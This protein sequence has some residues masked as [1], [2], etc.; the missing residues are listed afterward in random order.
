[1][2]RALLEALLLG[3]V[4][5]VC[6]VHVVLRRLAFLT[7]ALQHTVFPGVAIA[8]LAGQSLLL[9]AAA[10]AVLSVVLLGLTTRRPE[11]DHDGALALLTVGFFSIGVITVS[12]STSFQ[13][14]L[15]ALL[16]GRLLAVDNRQL[17]ETAALAALGIVVLVAV[18]KELLLRA[19]DPGGAAALG[20]RLPVLDLVLDLVVA[21]VVV[22]GARAAGTML[23]VGFVVTPAAA[24][25]LVC[26]RVPTMMVVAA[27]LAATCAWVGLGISFE[28]S[29]GH[30][31]RVAPGAAVV[32]AFTLV[33][34]VMAAT[35]AVVARTPRRVSNMGQP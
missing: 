1:M 29:V 25:R 35:R 6:G 23:V 2:A 26:R 3:T 20:Y 34:A 5:A 16:F 17:V 19:F 11:V 24:A 12:R 7:D 13:G 4:G 31:W 10:A 33:F 8:F 18:H 32:V 27:G 28:A 30:G 21:L 22:A 14:D 9:G 15:T